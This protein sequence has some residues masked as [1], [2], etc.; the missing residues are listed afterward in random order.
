M[1]PESAGHRGAVEAAGVVMVRDGTRAPPASS[2][3][4]P[5]TAHRDAA[6]EARLREVVRDHLDF[7][8]RSLRRLGLPAPLADDGAQRVFLV[9]SDRLDDIK[10]GSERAFLFKT[11]LHVA[12][13]EKRAFARRREVSLGDAATDPA[14][15]A[16][17]ADEALD[18]HRAR[19]VL[20]QLLQEMEMDLRAVFV[21]FELEELTTAEIA[22]TLEL[23]MGTV[24]SR[25]RRARE[26]FQRAAK[27]YHARAR[28]ERRGP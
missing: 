1:K 21:L 14:D 13:S 18:R 20:E 9:L 10:V 8:W 7:T 2:D 22:A 19:G 3:L 6:R 15:G 28:G 25:L 5:R 24:S 17:S 26:E 16:P 23:P 12:S 4:L 11:A 27:R